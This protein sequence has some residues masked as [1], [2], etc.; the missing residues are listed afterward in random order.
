MKYSVDFT[1]LP[2]YCTQIIPDCHEA[3]RGKPCPRNPD[4]NVAS[5]PFHHPQPSPNPIHVIGL[6]RSEIDLAQI[7]GFTRLWW[8]RPILSLSVAIAGKPPSRFNAAMPNLTRRR[9]PERYDCWH[10]YYGDV[11]VG[12]IARR[13]GNPNDTDQWE[14]NCGFYPGSN[15]GEDRYGTAPSFD[16]ARARLRAREPDRSKIDGSLLG[17]K[18]GEKDSFSLHSRRCD[19]DRL[20]VLVDYRGYHGNAVRIHFHFNPSG[21]ILHTSCGPLR[22]RA[23]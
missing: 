19:F 18:I 4:Q 16:A 15:P 10:V 13:T 3:Q 12:T 5:V 14:W 23:A 20:R 11:H 17:T 9:Y 8:P 6:Y 21:R 7:A 2:A 1:A 22:S